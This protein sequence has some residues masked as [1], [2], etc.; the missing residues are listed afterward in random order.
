[1]AASAN[2]SVY[3]M[4]QVLCRHLVVAALMTSLACSGGSGEK[5]TPDA[6]VKQDAP[7]PLPDA[8]PGQNVQLLDCTGLTPQHTATWTENG[9]QPAT[10]TVKVGDILKVEGTG[11]AYWESSGAW[12]SGAT[13]CL[14][15][16][17]PETYS[18]YCYTHSEEAH[19]VVEV[20]P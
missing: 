5:R 9:Q 1:M 10:I 12:T 11:H 16:F 17:T 19:G 2:G 14:R 3:D 18:T 13:S 8:P 15:F 4:Q 6:A 7:R 20:K